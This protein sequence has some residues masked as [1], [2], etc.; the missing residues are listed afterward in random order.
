MLL[1]G[2]GG[3]GYTKMQHTQYLL[4]FE[5]AKVTKEMAFLEVY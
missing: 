5:M 4:D 1:T 3:D 2:H